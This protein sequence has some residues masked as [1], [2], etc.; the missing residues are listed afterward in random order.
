[1]DNLKDIED[2]C[3]VCGYPSHSQICHDC[4]V[5]Q[6]GVDPADYTPHI[7]EDHW[8]IQPEDM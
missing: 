4:M 2:V 5:E 6:T 3:V 8:P 1:M 7:V